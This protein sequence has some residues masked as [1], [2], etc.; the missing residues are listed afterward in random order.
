MMT[1]Q[2]SPQLFNIVDITSYMINS[3][4]VPVLSVICATAVLVPNAI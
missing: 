4:Y 1:D 3:V 2:S